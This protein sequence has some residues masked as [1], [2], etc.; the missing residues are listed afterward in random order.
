M[1]E[2]VTITIDIHE[3]A[4]LHDYVD[5]H[6]D[7]EDWKLAELPAG[8]LSFGPVGFERKTMEDYIS[9]LTKGRL[10]EQAIKM[11]QRYE[12]AAILVEGDMFDTNTVQY[13]NIPPTAIR[14]SMASF[15]M[16]NDV[17]VFCCSDME[18]LVD[19]AVRLA[20]KYVEDETGFIPKSKVTGS[21]VPVTKKVFGCLDG[22][23]VERADLM[24]D[25]VQSVEDAAAMEEEDWRQIDGIGREL[26][27]SIV[28]QLRDEE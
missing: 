4:A 17:P 13:T 15:T 26:A 5:S 9:S 25:E 23:G 3:P 1:S 16:R 8:D 2:T 18:L 28:E 21:N 22:V 27:K 20:R 24:Y 10:K 12:Y 6:D 14:G 7:I 11:S 19:Y